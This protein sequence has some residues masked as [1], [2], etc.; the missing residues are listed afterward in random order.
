MRL[1]EHL[2]S[3][4]L[5]ASDLQFD[6][7][8]LGGTVAT[9]FVGVDEYT[10]YDTSLAYGWTNAIG[11]GVGSGPAHTDDAVKTFIPSDSLSFR[12]DDLEPGF[13]DVTAWVASPGPATLN[14]PS[15]SVS[16][17]ANATPVAVHAQL[18][19]TD[20]SGLTR[21]N[22]DGSGTTFVYANTGGFLT[23]LQGT[24]ASFAALSISKLPSPFTL[25]SGTIT[26]DARITSL[27][28]D[29][30]DTDATLTA[31]TGE[32]STFPAGSFTIIN[33]GTLPVTG[34]VTSIGT[35]IAQVDTPGFSLQSL[36][37]STIQ[38]LSPSTVVDYAAVQ[39]PIVVM[40]PSSGDDVFVA[41]PATQQFNAHSVSNTRY[42]VAVGF[43][44][45][46]DVAT[47]TGQDLAVSTF[48]ATL[49]NRVQVIGFDEVIA[50]V[51]QV[52]WLA[53]RDRLNFRLSFI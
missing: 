1:F 23:T 5:L 14:L 40:L 7:G 16:I 52:F 48:A 50:A 21:T 47:L 12:V 3:R 13:Y 39:T 2:E 43:S 27:H 37:P 22:P 25:A 53:D 38:V 51:D 15:G 11:Q 8:P 26:V 45:G 28:V 30:T 41:T 36:H 32:Q 35:V 24:D 18:L 49:N 20:D 44:G 46:N 6:F 31:N 42:T 10:F 29:L 19:V 4:D 34:T 17:P 33:A 9:G